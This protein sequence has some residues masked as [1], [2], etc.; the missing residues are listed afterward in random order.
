MI[1]VKEFWYD[2]VDWFQLIWDRVQWWTHANT[3][4][5]SIRG[6]EFLD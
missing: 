4:M 2:G 6:G 5:T 1:K 3:V